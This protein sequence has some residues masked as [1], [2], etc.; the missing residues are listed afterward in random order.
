MI[1]LVLLMFPQ[2]SGCLTV[3]YYYYILA[4]QYQ[5]VQLHDGWKQDQERVFERIQG[6][7][8]GPYPYC[9]TLCGQ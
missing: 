2:F 5:L 8:S 6:V 9:T 4:M 3:K 7:H 1:Y